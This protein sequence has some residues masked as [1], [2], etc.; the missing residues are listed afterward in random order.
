M[1][2]NF[3]IVKVGSYIKFVNLIKNIARDIL[4]EVPYCSY[5]SR[6]L[7]DSFPDMALET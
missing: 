1:I 2:N 3:S 7:M 6:S 4:G 5:P